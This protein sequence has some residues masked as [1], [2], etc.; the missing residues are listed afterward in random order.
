MKQDVGYIFV[1][2]VGKFFWGSQSDV[3]WYV[4]SEESCRTDERAY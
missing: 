2:L 3:K 1:G 4:S